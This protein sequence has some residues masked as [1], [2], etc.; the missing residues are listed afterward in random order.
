MRNS[1]R[2]PLRVVLPCLL[3]AIGSAT[4]GLVAATVLGAD[5]GPGREG[6][7]TVDPARDGALPGADRT[8]PLAAGSGDNGTSPVH[9][10]TDAVASSSPPVPAPADTVAEFEGLHYGTNDGIGNTIAP[11]DVQLAVGPGHVM[12]LVNWIG[13]I[14]TKDGTRVSTFR[15][16]T[17]FGTPPGEGLGDPKILYDSMSGR[18]FASAMDVDLPGVL[19][20]VSSSSDPTAPWR[21]VN[22][23]TPGAN[24]PDQPHLGL[25]EDKV[26]LAAT[27]FT[28]CRG[29]LVGGQYWVLNKADLLAGATPQLTTFGPSNLLTTIHPAQALGG[30]ATQYMVRTVPPATIQL[31][32][33]T[34][35][36]PGP[37]SVATTNLAVAPMG[38]LPDGIQPGTT[39]VLDSG[40]RRVQDA[41]WD[42]GELWLGLSDGCTPA[43]DTGTR[44]CI[45]LIEVGTE[46]WTVRQDFDVGTRGNDSLYPT[47]RP[48]VFGGLVVGF[49]LTSATTFPSASVA[50]RTSADRLNIL[51]PAIIVRAGTGVEQ[52]PEG[53]CPV[54]PVCR[55]GDYSGSGRDPADATIVWSGMEYSTNAG[56][57]TYIAA[58]RIGP[59]LATSLTA[60][61][62]L[63]GGG[64]GFDPPRL[65][66]VDGGV[67]RTLD[68]TPTPTTVSVD[69]GSPWNVTNPLVGSAV[70]E[71]WL[72]DQTTEGVA[73]SPNVIVI[74]YRHQ[75][76]VSFDFA[77]TGG[78]SGYSPPSVIYTYFDTG[79]T[80]EA[81]AD[82]WA[83]ANGSYV[84]EDPLPGSSPWESWRVDGG[85]GRTFAPGTFSAAYSHAYLDGF[86][87]GVVGP[88]PMA[89]ALLGLGAIAAVVVAVL[90]R[91]RTRRRRGMGRPR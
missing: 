10:A 50:I 82:V 6:R 52:P 75:V 69:P 22:L 42:R 14:W 4:A 17:L 1:K 80:T 64:G 38:A 21:T 63:V 84:F 25:T 23:T 55:Y 56:W 20:A 47:L 89:G 90:A 11:P 13:A 48:D 79:R 44:A 9:V 86:G 40:D 7:G 5:R 76:R 30:G 78:G 68:L 34:G 26:V 51:R 36:P 72:T 81:P 53:S 66:Y 67:R 19:L 57:G 88:G 65:A 31:F 32:E 49:S 18:W 27:L 45:R 70:Q 87:R 54:P 91:R 33:V 83:D 24:C 12:E 16:Q 59:S 77:V 41:F 73:G 43:G 28:D 15:L 3:L 58:S 85:T 2:G 8:P 46:N 61:Y 29:A 35:V 62:T 60:S 39:F 37:V 71:R 74:A